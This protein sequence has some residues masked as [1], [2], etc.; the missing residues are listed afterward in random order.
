MAERVTVTRVG[1]SG[2]VSV[3]Y[4]T[5]LR[6]DPKAEEVVQSTVDNTLNLMYESRVKAAERGVAAAEQSIVSAQEGVTAAQA[7]VEEFLA[8]R[9]YV[10]PTDALASIQSQITDFAL[11]A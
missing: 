10:A 2:L 11:A 5:P 1:D 7:R 3:S 6:D 8:A 4:R 9:G